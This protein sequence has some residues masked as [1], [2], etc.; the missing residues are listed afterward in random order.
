VAVSELFNMVNSCGASHSSAGNVLT[1]S[2]KSARLCRPK[3]N[4]AVTL[5]RS[6]CPKNSVP[7]R[8]GST[9][10]RV[11]DV[12]AKIHPPYRHPEFT[13]S[14]ILPTID[15]MKF[16]A[17]IPAS[18]ARPAAYPLVRAARIRSASSRLREPPRGAANDSVPGAMVV[19]DTPQFLIAAR[20]Q[21][22]SL[23][24]F[25]MPQL[26]FS[27]RHKIA[28]SSASFTY[29]KERSTR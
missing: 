7:R 5:S 3:S 22:P 17:T 21:S 11:D 24:S 23:R 26:A 13:F 20:Q 14:A 18:D 6:L 4:S 9:Q 29:R 12:R 1:N 27:N 8:E 19:A 15:V 25:G 16:S 10:L 28:S 2:F